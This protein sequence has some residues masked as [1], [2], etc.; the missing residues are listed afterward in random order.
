M[1]TETGEPLWNLYLQKVGDTYRLIMPDQVDGT[2]TAPPQGADIAASWPVNP[3]FTGPSGIKMLLSA[4][5][6]FVD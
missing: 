2:F 6:R 4:H 1:K 3:H 5:Y